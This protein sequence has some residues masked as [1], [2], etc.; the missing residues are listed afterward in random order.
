MNIDYLRISYHQLE[1]ERNAC[2]ERSK[3]VEQYLDKWYDEILGAHDR[4]KYN[5]EGNVWKSDS[6]DSFTLV[7]FV[8]Q[9]LQ[10]RKKFVVIEHFVDEH[11]MVVSKYYSEKRP[12]FL[13]NNFAW[14]LCN[15]DILTLSEYEKVRKLLDTQ[16]ELRRIIPALKIASD[17]F[18]RLIEKEDSQNRK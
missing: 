7:S 14:A 9:G 3:Q 11:G 1:V 8:R 12:E 10:K 13:L 17:Y 15:L 16:S 4:T 5:L 18:A 6:V 2:I